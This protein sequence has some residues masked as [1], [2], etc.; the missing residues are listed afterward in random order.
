MKAVVRLV[1]LAV[2]AVVLQHCGGI[3]PCAQ[4][5]Q[6]SVG[7]CRVGLPTDWYNDDAWRTQ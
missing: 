1:V 4:I 5:P 6:K 7:A 2:L 3:A